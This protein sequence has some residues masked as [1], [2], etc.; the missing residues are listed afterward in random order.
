VQRAKGD[1]AY[2]NKRVKTGMSFSLKNVRFEK[3]GNVWVPME[4][5]M[6]QAEDNG[7]KTTKWHHK[8]TEMALNPDFEA[9]KAFAADD[10]PEGTKVIFKGQDDKTEYTWQD[11]HPVEKG[12]SYNVKH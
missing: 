2:D 4:A 5:D 11:G 10:I 6:Q 8:R 3:I 1:L 9:L 7:S 12:G